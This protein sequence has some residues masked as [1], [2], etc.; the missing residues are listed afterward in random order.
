MTEDDPPTW[1]WMR[2]TEE[3]MT[4]FTRVDRERLFLR[5]RT[6]SANGR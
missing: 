3:T 2:I 1:L 4:M 6:A 5:P